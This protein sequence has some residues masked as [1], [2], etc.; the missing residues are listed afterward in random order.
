MDNKALLSSLNL[1]DLAIPRNNA[2][3]KRII[4]ASAFIFFD[5][6]STLVFCRNFQEEANPLARLFME[7]LGIFLGLTLFVLLI[8]VPIYVTLS[9]DSHVV[10]LPSRLAVP[11]GVLVDVAFAWWIGGAHFLGG[12][13]WF[14]VA[15]DLT[16][17]VLGAILY[18]G[19]AFV[20]I[21]PWRRTKTD[22]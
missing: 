3:M 19:L 12:S 13:S 15:P 11:F 8:N 10:R 1:R 6:A 17:Q 20:M 18:L 2:W 22:N 21:K 16:R 4:L 9:V 14:W 7:N 5:Y